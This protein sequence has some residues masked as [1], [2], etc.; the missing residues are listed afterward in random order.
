MVALRT[1]RDEKPRTVTFTARHYRQVKRV[2][3]SRIEWAKKSGFE[4]IEED[5]AE[6]FDALEGAPVA[7]I[8]DLLSAADGI[9]ILAALRLAAFSDPQANRLID[10]FAEA[11]ET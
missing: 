10:S 3:K 2:Y 4:D 7:T 1:P 5:A 9:L 6:I 11:Y 8:T